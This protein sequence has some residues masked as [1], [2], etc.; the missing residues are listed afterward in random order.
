[1]ITLR[2]HW[3]LCSIVHMLASSEITRYDHSIIGCSRRIYIGVIL[4][5]HP[6]RGESHIQCN[7]NRE[8]ATTAA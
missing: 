8:V 4:R 5:A 3:S 7:A 2:V 1:M 6:V